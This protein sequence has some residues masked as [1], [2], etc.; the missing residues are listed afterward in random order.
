MI[1]AAV[2]GATGYT[3][4]ELVRI[5]STHK[6][7]ELTAITSR[8]NPATLFSEIFPSFKGI[9]SLKTEEFDATAISTKADLVF[10]ALPHG[11]A[12]DVVASL[13][14][15]GLKV[16][17]L[18]ADFRFSSLS[19]YEQWY[20]GHSCPELLKET[21][22]GLPELNRERIAN[23]RLVANP[24]CYPTSV[25][26]P[27]M[28]LI[29]EDR[30][31]NES[32]VVNSASGASGAGRSAIV[33]NIYCEVNDS[34]KAYKVGE[35]RHTPEIEELLSL[36]AGEEL[37]ISFTPHLI[38]MNRGICST[39][40]AKLKNNLSTKDLLKI[41]E[42]FYHKETFVR[43]YPEGSYPD[44]ANVRGSNYCDI[45]LKVDERT[46]RVVIVSVIDNLVKG[47]AGQ[48]VQ[49]MNIMFGIDEGEGLN[50]VPFSI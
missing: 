43:I 8:S 4:L 21:V 39:I 10:V 50:H 6:D 23:A 24:G 5:L 17:D 20:G 13:L 40:T 32:V 27:L 3:G 30:I 41:L 9:V 47:A 34:F 25:I 45:G 29:K 12:M 36:A 14:T 22:Y 18:S 38:P 28:P 1:R 16:I 48:A 31:V 15:E 44:T 42:D 11:S 33:S 26:L 37:L 19:T 35:H 7:V 49:N 2:V 46:G